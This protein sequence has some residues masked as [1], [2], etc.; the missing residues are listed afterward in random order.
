MT[1]KKKLRCTWP[2]SVATQRPCL[3]CWSTVALASTS[4]TPRERHHCTVLLS[5]SNNYTVAVFVTMFLYHAGHCMLICLGKWGTENIP[6]QK[7]R[8]PGRQI[9]WVGDWVRSFL[10]ALAQ[11]W[12]PWKNEI[13]HKGSLRD[14]PQHWAASVVR[15]ECKGKTEG[16]RMMPELWIHA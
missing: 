12:R 10:Y 4:G 14:R 11:Q 2:Q 9:S 6:K 7:L 15:P 8:F 5:T 16:M 1:A 13:C 3:R